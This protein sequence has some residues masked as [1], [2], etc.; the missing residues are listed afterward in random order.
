MKRLL[1][2]L[3]SVIFAC[4]WLH[5][6]MGAVTMETAID[7]D[8][9]S[10]EFIQGIG[11]AI[12]D[13]WLHH[14]ALRLYFRKLRNINAGKRIWEGSYMFARTLWN[15]YQFVGTIE[16]MMVIAHAQN[17]VQEELH[18]AQL[19]SKVLPGD[20]HAAEL[21]EHATEGHALGQ[22]L[23]IDGQW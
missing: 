14:S 13:P 7:Q 23:R 4:F 10:K 15:Q 5:V 18:W 3:P 12:D 17:N 11:Q 16:V 22:R 8:L 21:M 2:F 9:A 1:F 19:Y 6:V 20:A